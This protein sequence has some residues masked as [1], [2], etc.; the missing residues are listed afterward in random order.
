[1]LKI[2]LQESEQAVEIVLEGRVA[3][4]WVAELSRV[5]VETAPRLAS[6]KLTLDLRNITY[7]DS[8]GKQLLKTI[9][10]PTRAKLLSSSLWTQYLA[11]EISA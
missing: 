4:P 11:E 5:W 10:D 2:T 9:Y 3:G 1:M 6:R 7:A 8:G